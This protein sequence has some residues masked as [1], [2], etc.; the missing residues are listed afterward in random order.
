MSATMATMATR[1]Q[2]QAAR[3]GTLA[4]QNKREGARVP[5]AVPSSFASTEID[6]LQ[7][8]KRMENSQG[9]GPK[10]PKGKQPGTGTLSALS[11][12]LSS[13]ALRSDNWRGA[14][15]RRPPGG[16]IS[17]ATSVDLSFVVGPSQLCGTVPVAGLSTMLR[18]RL[19][20]VQTGHTPYTRISLLQACVLE[21]QIGAAG[22]LVS[23]H[24][25]CLCFDAHC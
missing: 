11:V 2:V 7:N 5:G 9:M 8:D 12:L 13:L 21:S 20:P 1:E 25:P 23:S 24:P 19:Q 14:R 10:N 17:A 18:L 15:N 4:Q 3:A 6:L 16:L 22:L